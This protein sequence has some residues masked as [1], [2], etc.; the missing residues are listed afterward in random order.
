MNLSEAKLRPDWKE[1]EA[2]YNLEMKAIFDMGT[3]SECILPPG[4]KYV[5]SKLVFK[6]KRH[7]NGS[8]ERYKVRLVVKGYSQLRDIAFSKQHHL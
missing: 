4:E 8:I 3:L 5:G 7:A 1:W 6:I 2:A